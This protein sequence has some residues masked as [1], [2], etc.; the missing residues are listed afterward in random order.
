MLAPS[1]IVLPKGALG[2]KSRDTLV[3]PSFWPDRTKIKW[4]VS[5]RSTPESK[6]KSNSPLNS[7]VVHSQPC[8]EVI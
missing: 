3:Y 2:S 1:G 7:P 4:R 8:P 6:S 5:E